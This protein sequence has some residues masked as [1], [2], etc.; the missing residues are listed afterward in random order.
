[1][2]DSSP[3]KCQIQLAPKTT[4]GSGRYNI[5][6]QCQVPGLRSVTCFQGALTEGNKNSKILSIL[7]KTGSGPGAGRGLRMK[8]RLWQIWVG[9]LGRVGAGTYTTWPF[10]SLPT[11]P[12][13]YST[14]LLSVLAL[15][16]RY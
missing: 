9:K 10:L 1:M 15:G 14:L 2:S 3:T 7:I 12:Y 13:T 6:N 4:G 11:S 16:G 5:A 8:S